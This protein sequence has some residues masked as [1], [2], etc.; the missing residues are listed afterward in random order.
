MIKNM[1][2]NI[3]VHALMLIYLCTKLL[4][5]DIEDVNKDITIQTLPVI[6]ILYFFK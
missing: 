2:K 4:S 6:I 3:D 1:S 5:W